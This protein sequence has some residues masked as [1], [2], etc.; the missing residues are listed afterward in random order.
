MI[1]PAILI[2]LGLIFLGVNYGFLN[3]DIWTSLWR[4]WPVIIVIAGISILGSKYIPRKLSVII[5][6]ILVAL[7]ALGAYYYSGFS[8][9]KNPNQNSL[10]SLEIDEPLSS[11][12]A[13]LELSLNLGAQN[14]AINST[15]SGLVTGNISSYGTTPTMKVTQSAG[16][17]KV[18]IG[19][20]WSLRSP[21]AWKDIK[22]TQSSL[23]LTDQIPVKTNLNLGATE[24]NAD[25][26]KVILTDLA[27]KTG[28]ISGTVK[29]G[30]RSA[31][32]Y[33]DINCGASNIKLSVPKSSGLDV[34]QAT[35][36]V[37]I[38]Y[39]NIEMQ[40][41]DGDKEKKS[42]GFDGSTGK[43]YVNLRAGASSI[44]F[45]SY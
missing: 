23:Y 36:A 38:S 37:K 24:I 32:L 41:V 19:Q 11:D 22:S 39:N 12:T 25:L 16:V 33:V 14:I 35:G 7:S 21:W 9:N 1:F 40:S 30:A 43:I 20:K 5:I 3:H 34:K 27:L 18:A 13:K 4:F 44:E 31:N 29:L 28:A 8:G 2:I 45:D 15:K 42:S 6:I 10:G 17:A 26:S